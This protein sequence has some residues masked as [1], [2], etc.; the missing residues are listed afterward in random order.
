M[1]L[2]RLLR[3]KRKA[4]QGLGGLL[5]LVLCASSD[6][7]VKYKYYAHQMEIQGTSSFQPWT[8]QVNE[9]G[10]H[11]D[12]HV[13]A[14]G[15]VSLVGPSA[16]V[17]RVGSIVAARHSLMDIQI[18]KALK[19]ADH[20]YL[21]FKV[22]KVNTKLFPNKVTFISGEGVMNVGG[23]SQTVPLR[24]Y[25]RV[26]PNG[27]VELWGGQVLDIRSL[28][29]VPPS[30]FWGIYHYNPVISVTFSIILRKER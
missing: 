25:A 18:Y 9:M 24:L 10:V 13:N 14:G 28:S 17:I 1:K 3:W 5:L 22:T 15:N 6:G 2:N 4:G 21:T 19:G 16:L 27:D 11:A 12:L 23:K 8:V 20:P 7:F 26:L 29:V 30:A